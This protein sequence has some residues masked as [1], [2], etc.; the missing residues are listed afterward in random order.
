HRCSFFS[1]LVFLFSAR[2]PPT[3]PLFPYTTLFRSGLVAIEEP[4][5]AALVGLDL[6]QQQ[7][8]AVVLER[9]EAHVADACRA[10]QPG[11]EQVA[12][13]DPFHPAVRACLER[14]SDRV[15]LVG[16]VGPPREHR[17]VLTEQVDEP[18]LAHGVGGHVAPPV[19]CF[20]RNFLL[21]TRMR[22]RE[23]T[24]WCRTSAIPVFHRS[25]L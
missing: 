1:F 25:H 6:Q 3:P 8:L 18:V 13:E 20:V 4:G 21:A 16:S 9:D 23:M 24:S 12:G 10:V 5:C 19:W 15:R 17:G 22:R 2:R 11:D 7:L 14:D